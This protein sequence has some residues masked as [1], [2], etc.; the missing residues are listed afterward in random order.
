RAV[1]VD[2]EAVRLLVDV[3]G[4]DPQELA[5]EVDKIATWAAGAAVGVRDVEQLAAGCAEIPGYEL[6]DAWG[7]R[8]LAA[9][10]T[11]CQTLLERSGEPVSRT[12][13]G[14]VGLMVGHVGRVRDCQMFAEEGLSAREA[15]A[16][17]KRHPF[18]VEKL[19][20]QARNYGPDEL[21]GA[22]VRLAALD[23]AV[24]GGS[25]LAVDL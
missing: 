7:R 14:L 10:L 8:D 19:Y 22:V 15:A 18:Y 25:R 16:R 11:A 4:E 6:T 3:V 23:H 24:K 1:E 2:A 13:P 9:A 20:A 17:L 21:R 12:V 5:T